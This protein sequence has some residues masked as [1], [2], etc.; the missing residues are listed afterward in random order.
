MPR[1]LLQI[2]LTRLVGQAETKGVGGAD[3]KLRRYRHP[4]SDVTVD[5]LLESGERDEA[6]NEGA[7][8]GEGGRSEDG[9]AEPNL[10]NDPC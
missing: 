7:R 4:I 8:K 9:P 3:E 1:T 5:V 6:L 10:I 2:S